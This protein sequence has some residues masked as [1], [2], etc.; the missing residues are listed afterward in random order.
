MGRQVKNVDVGLLTDKKVQS[1]GLWTGIQVKKLKYVRIC[2]TFSSRTSPMNHKIYL[3][4]LR[5]F[6]LIKETQP[7]F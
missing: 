2:N 7:F 5:F 4:D 3:H 1:S 6:H